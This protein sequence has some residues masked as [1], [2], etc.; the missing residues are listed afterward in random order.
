MRARSGTVNKAASRRGARIE[1]PTEWSRMT[2][3]AAMQMKI[4]VLPKRG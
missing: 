1:M 4:E 3:I 2:I